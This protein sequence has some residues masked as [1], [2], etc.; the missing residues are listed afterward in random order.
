MRVS[1]ASRN[2]MIDVWTAL[3]DGGT[4]RIYDG[5]RPA[6]PEPAV[7]TQTLLAEL[8]FHATAFV[9]A[10]SASAT[11]N[12]ITSDGS[13]NATGTA[14]CARVL[15]SGGTAVGDL[16]VTATGGGGDLTSPTTAIV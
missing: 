3:L 2:S 12:A 10:S 5:T 13:A 7:S 16:T 4:L 9:A 8:T 15:A 1:T 14:S 6:T 11:A